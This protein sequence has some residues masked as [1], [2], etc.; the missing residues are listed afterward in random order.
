MNHQQRHELPIDK[1]VDYWWDHVRSPDIDP[2]NFSAIT[3]A[4]WQW[5]EEV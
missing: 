4:F 5:Y 3:N 1:V 2:D